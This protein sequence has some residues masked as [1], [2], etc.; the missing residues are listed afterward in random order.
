MPATMTEIA[1][2]AQVSISLVSRLTRGDKALR[3]S[4]GKR[5]EVMKVIER[6]GGVKHRKKKTSPNV[7][8][9][10][11]HN[12][13]MPVNRM[14]SVDWVRDNLSNT[15]FVKSLENALK[16]KGY[17]MSI[18]FF[19]EEKML[20]DFSDLI[21]SREYCDG[22]V[23]GHGIVN[24]GISHLL[25]TTNYPHIS[26]SLQAENYA[27][28]TV[29][30]HFM[31]GMR[32]AIRHLTK[33]GHRRIGY[34]GIRRINELFISR[35]S[36]FVAGLI[37]A[38]LTLNDKNVVA[39]EG[40]QP[41]MN[42]HACREEACLSF[43]QW[44]DAGGDVTAVI[45]ECDPFALGVISAMKQRSL[46]P[47]VDISVVGDSYRKGDESFLD[48]KLTTISDPT[49]AMGVRC[50]DRLIQQIEGIQNPSDVIHERVAVELVVGETTGTCRS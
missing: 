17:R 42:S 28:N 2:E 14:F 46:Q 16:S 50:A 36:T 30:P 45:C 5:R 34:I 41:S 27:V 39:V 37:E 48:M 26:I 22:M 13:V 25:K 43:G 12:I 21:R 11:A 40:Y 47:G 18:S 4:D 1:R 33:L 35:Y 8:T 24:A 44:L 19:D 3:I 9:A 7:K 6:F 31:G 38:G 15:F 29:C 10:L 32:L 23:L 49:S 20:E